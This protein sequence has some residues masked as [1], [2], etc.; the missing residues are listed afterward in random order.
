MAEVNFRKKVMTPFLK[1]QVADDQVF[2][3]VHGLSSPEI[4]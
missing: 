1:T 2:M 3:Y 4:G